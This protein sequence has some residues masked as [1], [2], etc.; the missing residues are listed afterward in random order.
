MKTITIRCVRLERFK[1]CRTIEAKAALVIELHLH[2]LLFHPCH[3]LPAT[4]FPSCSHSPFDCTLQLCKFLENKRG[5]Q[6][7]L[8]MILVEL[9]AGSDAGACFNHIS[10]FLPLTKSSTV[11]FCNF[12]AFLLA[13]LCFWRFHIHHA[14]YKNLLVTLQRFLEAKPFFTAT[15][16]FCT[17]LGVIEMQPVATESCWRREEEYIYWTLLWE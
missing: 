12:Y 16:R 10:P 4:V 11:Y 7:Y 13:F 8:D 15:F 2:Q 14:E 3:P 5:R 17:I 1:T 6:L 9:L